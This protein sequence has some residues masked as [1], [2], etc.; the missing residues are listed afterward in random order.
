MNFKCN[1][2][3]RKYIVGAIGRRY[4]KA[5]CLCGEKISIPIEHIE[6]TF[7]TVDE[8]NQ[9]EQWLN[10]NSVDWMSKRHY[11]EQFVDKESMENILASI[12]RILSYDDLEKEYIIFDKEMAMLFK[13][14][15]G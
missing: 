10:D 1:S 15:W 13:L 5:K 2:C 11:D 9:A 7:N 6:V 4:K 8:V 14:T 3:N 12:R